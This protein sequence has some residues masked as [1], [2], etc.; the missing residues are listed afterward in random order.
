LP[1]RKLPLASE[2]LR[3]NESTVTIS[4]D[5]PSTSSDLSPSNMTDIQKNELMLPTLLGTAAS[6]KT[7]K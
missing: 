2:K 5:D 6:Q 7:V 1:L 3:R 4:T